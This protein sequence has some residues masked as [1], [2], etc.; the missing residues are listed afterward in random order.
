LGKYKE[1]AS[2]LVAG[3]YIEEA[4]R[5]YQK[6][7]EFQR[8]ADLYLSV[9][10]YD[11]AA[12]VLQEGG[13]IRQGDQFIGE[14]CAREERYS[15][16]AHHFER[17]QDFNQAGEM[18]EL[19]G[20]LEKAGEMFLKG[21]EYTK[22]SELFV[23]V[24]DRMRA[25]Q[26]ME[27][28][29]RLEEAA[30]LYCELGD[31]DKAVS[32]LEHESLFFEAAILKREQG[33]IEESILL[34]QKVDSQS[35]DYSEATLALARLFMDQGM[36][37]P[38]REKYQRALARRPVTPETIEPFYHLATL[39]ERLEDWESAM[40]LYERILAEDFQYKDVKERL[41]ILK[42]DQAEGRAARRVSDTE[43]EVI[44]NRY[45]LLRQIGR[46]GMGLVYQ[47]EDMVLKR[48]VAYKILPESV[49]G[50]PKV[51]ESFIQEART[52][53]SIQHTNIV[54]IFD[55]G[56]SGGEYYI[57]MEYVDGMS[58]KELLEK[59]PLLPITDV[60]LISEQICAGLDYAHSKRVIHRDIKPGNVM[61]SREKVVKIMDFGLAKI[62]H[63]SMGETTGVKGTPLYMS[64]EQILGKE[65]DQQSDIY[66]L[67]CT[68]FRMI[69][70]KPP[71]SGGD[72]FY[73]H[74]HTPPLEPAV[75]NPK[76]PAYL[77]RIILKCLEKD[78]RKRYSRVKEVL[79]D[80]AKGER[81]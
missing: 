67:G 72:V 24:G 64:P 55:T 77:N 13:D 53:A 11:K 50:N 81:G 71:F 35:E 59:T 31:V 10:Q 43:T 7:G 30:R 25:A 26:A 69:T 27:R 76:I 56:Q 80:L 36:Y 37:G 28:G 18:Y 2:I 58:L 1:A 60:I 8:A 39:H 45:R 22:A 44:E 12:E 74:L 70:G 46:G 47:A 6:A 57:T 68:I 78:K 42:R 34:L 63:D 54:T 32:L 75:L 23:A 17:A 62:V 49:R 15:E 52:A 19:D 48:I 3:G 51:L 38:A 61:V 4:A 79:G 29:Q 14:K 73:Q 21:G 16:A 20:N 33:K 41:E 5:A 9:K 65:V 66:S 40:V